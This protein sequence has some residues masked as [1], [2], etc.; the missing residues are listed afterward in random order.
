VQWVALA[1][2]CVLCAHL[3]AFSRGTIATMGGRRE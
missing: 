2:L 3:W 1:W